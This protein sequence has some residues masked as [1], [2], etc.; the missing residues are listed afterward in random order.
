[1]ALNPLIN[2][3]IEAAAG[4]EHRDSAISTDNYSSNLLGERQ[5]GPYRCFVAKLYPSAC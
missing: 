2:S 4:N 3:E 1:M 5:L